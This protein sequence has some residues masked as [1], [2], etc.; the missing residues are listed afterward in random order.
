MVD[1]DR[2][3]EPAIDPRA[4]LIEAACEWY[5]LRERKVHPNAD[6]LLMP[7]LFAHV[8]AIDQAEERF[9]RAVDA[10]L[11]GEREQVRQVKSAKRKAR[12]ARRRRRAPVVLGG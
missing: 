2:Q 10:V 9:W 5:R 8:C 3:Q 12:D 11:A 4:A 7:A 1:G 6:G